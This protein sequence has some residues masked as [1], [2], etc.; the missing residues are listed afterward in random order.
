MPGCLRK[1]FVAWGP[2]II[3][4]RLRSVPTQVDVFG[5]NR[6]AP[7]PGCARSGHFRLGSRLRLGAV[8]GFDCGGVA[9]MKNKLRERADGVGGAA[10]LNLAP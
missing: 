1:S 6:L 10:T 2:E 8:F 3:V 9:R 7:W 4:T 5:C